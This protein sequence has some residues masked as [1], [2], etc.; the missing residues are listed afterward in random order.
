MT[1]WQLRGLGALSGVLAAAA[2][3]GIAEGVAVLVAAPSPIVSVGEDAIDRTPLAVK[4]FAIRTFGENDKT[5]LVLGVVVVLAVLA[6]FAGSLGITRPRIALALTAAIGMVG[7]ITAAVGRTVATTQTARV[8]PALAALAVSVVGLYVLLRAIRGTSDLSP[9]A[10]EASAPRGFDRRIFLA[11]AAAVSVVGLIGAA[12]T[13]LGVNKA[14]TASRDALEVPAPASAAAPVPVGVE[15]GVEGVAPFVTPNDAFY[16][17]DTAISPP[18]IDATTWHL[19][20]HGM[21]DKELNLSFA[22]LVNRPLMERDITLTCVSNEVGGPYVGNARWIGASLADL[23]A[24][25]GVQSGADALRSTAIDGFTVG[26]PIAAVT[27]GRDAMLAVSMNGEPLPFAHGFP[28]RMVVP[29]LYGYV[30]ATK[31]VVDIEVTKF[32]DFTA[33]WTDRGWSAEGPIKTES[34]IDAPKPFAAVTGM[35]AVAGVAWAQNRGVTDVA[36]RFDGEGDWIPA[37]LATED[38]ID[39]WRQW[40]YRWD[41]SK[42]EKGSHQI[43]VRATDADAYTQTGDRVPT[44]PDGATGWHTVAVTVK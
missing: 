31:W 1:K 25:A 23:L 3:V 44:V 4:D 5:V 2:G 30:S 38:T 7:V 16:R 37:E 24:E 41:T 19:R 8:L 39:T 15:V 20:I 9:S 35:V 18:Q 29:G 43:E 33:Y 21:V 22:D 26:T 10:T 6:A 13:K 32:A 28:V 11:S 42:V 27:D 14:A 36:V 40:V 17:V 12:A 34:R